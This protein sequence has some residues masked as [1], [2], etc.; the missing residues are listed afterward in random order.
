MT[1]IAAV[2]A[3]GARGADG[4]VRA[5]LNAAPH[6]GAEPPVTWS[7]GPVTLGHRA[8]AG[9]D[10]VPRSPLAVGAGGNA[11]VFDGRLDN[12]ADLC[13]ALGAGAPIEDAALALAAY[14][15]WAEDA[16]AHLLGEF[17]FALWD[18]AER[19]L[20][21]A[22]DVFGQRPLFLASRP[23]VT[24][25]ASEP[26]QLLAHPAVRP[27]L[28]EGAVA[29]YLACAP[30]SM[31]ETIWADVTRLPPAHAATVSDAGVRRYRYWDFDPDARLEY[32]RHGEYAEHF[33]ALFTE[34]IACRTRDA[35]SIGVFLTGGL[36]SSAI[37]GVAESIGRARGA[38]PLR[39]YSMVFPGW[40]LDQTQ[41]IDAVVRQWRL[42]SI[43]LNGRSATRAEIE[44]D[45]A[46]F[47]DIPTCP[48]RS[49][50]DPLRRAAAQEVDVLLTGAGG[51]DWF[52]GS[53]FHT[54]DLLR[55]GQ[56]A[57]AIRQYRDDVALP[58]RG[59]TRAGLLRLALAPLLPRA[60]RAILRPLAGARRP[61]YAWIRPEFAARVRLRDRLRRPPRP[62]CRTFVQAEI[63]RFAND[64]S[65]VIRYE[66][67]DR[68]TCAAGLDQ[69]HPFND[70]RLAEFGHALP[71]SQRWS[72]GE[73][74]VVMREA[75]AAE[76]P[77]LVR[78]RNDQAEC[79]ST[80]IDA[81]EALGGRACLYRLRS[82]EAGWVDGAVI[83]AMYDEMVGLYRRGHESYI[84]LANAVWS[85]TAVDL[86]LQQRVAGGRSG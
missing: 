74:K 52:A 49:V 82:A 60:A 23:A 24:A 86:W 33:R 4:E 37:A 76:L 70:R 64:V 61:A 66:R 34:A 42:P 54:A 35:A 58:G 83:Q 75:L 18:A 32:A 10:G 67:E 84:P 14:G 72:G 16:P 7:S 15:K 11:I 73:T 59:F 29:E 55:Q 2:F 80:L 20:V 57:A 41:Y 50:L 53:P 25:V 9:R 36:D 21:V 26:Q 30:M 77:P 81:I 40:D 79:A 78:Q 48:N 62:A 68:A 65:R 44:T 46:R 28:N 69:R 43:R 31:D 39:A 1:A 13:A 17:A 38:G 19:R 12:R 56:I 5:M 63:H 47:R 8:S 71:E 3:A 51:D 27:D 6:R 45:V 85:V 22:R